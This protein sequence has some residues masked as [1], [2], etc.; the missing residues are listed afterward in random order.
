MAE[1]KQNKYDTLSKFNTLNTQDKDNTQNTDSTQGTQKKLGRP[2]LKPEE[3]KRG[4]RYN[5][6]LDADLKQY[7][8]EM[9]WRQRTSITQWV[10]DLIRADME[11]YFANGGTK[12]G[13][14]DE[15]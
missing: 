5:L 2:T 1:K 4:Y 9:A 15:E 7:M 12:E 3:R 6:L 11:A 10:N 8:H 13:W 14:A